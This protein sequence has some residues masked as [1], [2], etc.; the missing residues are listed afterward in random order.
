MP[1]TPHRELTELRSYGGERTRAQ[2][3]E[4]ASTDELVALLRAA[5]QAG[6]RV[7]FRGGGHAIDSQSLNTDLVI[8][9]DRLA[10]SSFAPDGSAVT[11]GP[12]V[13]TGDLASAALSRGS[14]PPVLV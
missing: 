12:G 1:R 6:R 3:A 4:P 11:V 2:L 13:T 9:T 7:T 10:S 8:G 14:L 5:G